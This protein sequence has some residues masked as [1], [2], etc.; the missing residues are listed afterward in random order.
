MLNFDAEVIALTE[1]WINSKKIL[2]ILLGYNSFATTNH[3]NQ[4]DGIVFFVKN[5]LTVSSSE[6]NLTHASK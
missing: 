5:S 6:I 1:C 2:P 4:N 3:M